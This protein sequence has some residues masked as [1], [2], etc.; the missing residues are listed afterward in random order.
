MYLEKIELADYRNYEKLCICP[1][2]KINIIYGSNAQGKTNLLEAIYQGCTSR[3]HKSVKDRELIRFTKNEAHIKINLR[4]NDIP[5]R[6][7]IHIKKN[8]PK[9]IAVNGVLLKR[10]VDLLGVA[11]V[12]MFSPEDL[13]II[14]NG[15][16]ERRRFLDTELCQLDRIYTH[17]LSSYNRVLE[18]KNT[19]LKTNPNLSMLSIYNEQLLSYGSNI[20]EKRKKFI[21]DLSP[22]I[23]KKHFSLTDNKEEIE[24]IYE[25][26][27]MLFNDERE[28]KAGMSLYGPHRDDFCLNINGT[29]IR[30]FGSQG[31]QRTAAITLKL[32]EIDIV[33]KI[34]GDK[35]VLLLDDVFSELDR[36]RQDMLLGSLEDIQVFITCTGID[37]LIERRFRMD[38]IFLVRNGEIDVRR[39]EL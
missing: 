12:V 23:K 36:K 6:I 16:S 14:K 5:Y 39:E 8:S 19:M 18:Q 31:Q 26:N 37:D 2:E 30:K 9:G 4:K 3:S 10:A 29:D 28:I 21:D 20:Q 25:K 33:D 17:N 13:S 1:S 15:P 38:R 32:S 22:L 7:D 34:I 27:E 11:N 24:I 35:P